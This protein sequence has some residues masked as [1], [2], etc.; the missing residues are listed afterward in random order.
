MPE[1]GDHGALAARA[2]H[3]S[4]RGIVHAGLG[5]VFFEPRKRPPHRA[6]VGLDDA[7]VAA[8]QR[9]QRHRLGRGERQVAPGPVV[10]FP[11]ADTAAEALSGAVRHFARQHLTEGV[12]IDRAFQAQL[13]GAPAPP[14]TRRPVLRGILGVVAVALVVVCA[15][16]RAR[17]RAD[18]RDHQIQRP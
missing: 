4:V 15:L 2:D 16:R 8:D 10:D 17:H 9:G 12:R 5:G 14:G 7:I 18:G 13:S 11:A 3:V 6:V 1:G